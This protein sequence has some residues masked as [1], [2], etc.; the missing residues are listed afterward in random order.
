MNLVGYVVLG[1]IIVILLLV[2]ALFVRTYLV[3]SKGY[4][5][6]K[7]VNAIIKEDLGD[8]K[9]ATGS[10]TIGV[11]RFRVFH[12]YSVSFW[13]DGNEYV[14]EAELKN[15]KLNVGDSIEIRYIISKKGK[16][17]LKSEAYLCWSREMAVG[18]TLGLILGI[19]LSVLKMKG[20][21]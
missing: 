11:P 4:R 19:V 21:I 16:L 7:R 20:I 10:I 18:Y 2:Y 8:L 12:R 9:L 13:L 1:I 6:A 14:E 15:C 5:Q 3:T 17:E